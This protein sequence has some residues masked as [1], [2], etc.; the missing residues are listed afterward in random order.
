MKKT[1][2]VKNTSGEWQE[3]D[4]SELK[5]T[6]IIHGEL[7]PEILA[8][9]KNVHD[10]LRE[11]ICFNGQPMCLELFE[12]GFMREVDPEV[13]LDVW[14][15]IAAAFQKA[16]GMFPENAKPQI[17]HWLMLLVMGAVEDADKERREVQ[18][19]TQCFASVYPTSK[20]A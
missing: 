11:V 1:I 7:S 13:S 16:S 4:P 17:Y 12:I 15:A 3:I 6:R 10:L 18:I 5:E 14:D 2:R 20:A 19:I 8:R 9:I